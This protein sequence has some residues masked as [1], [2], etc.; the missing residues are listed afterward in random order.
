MLVFIESVSFS[1]ELKTLLRWVIL[2]L[3]YFTSV[4]PI[5]KKELTRSKHSKIIPLRTLLFNKL[6]ELGEASLGMERMGRVTGSQS[7]RRIGE[8]LKS[9][10]AHPHSDK[11]IKKSKLSPEKF[12]FYLQRVFLASKPHSK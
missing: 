3:E 2:L 11:S 12:T 1:T 6:A 10:P 5:Y 8:S 4:N 7:G 9:N